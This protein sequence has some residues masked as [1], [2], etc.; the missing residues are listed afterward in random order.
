MK[1]TMV[2]FLLQFAGKT[3]SQRYKIVSLI[4][5]V[6]FFLA[7]LPGIFIGIGL[8]IRQH[9]TINA[10]RTIELTVSAAGITAGLFFL[11]W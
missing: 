9:I 7:V 11:V 1:R 6:L 5:G 3:N 8:F 2:N 10:G 4:F